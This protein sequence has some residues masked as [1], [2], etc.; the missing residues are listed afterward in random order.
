MNNS[1]TLHGYFFKCEYI[2]YVE[3][4]NTG[5]FYYKDPIVIKFKQNDDGVQGVSSGGKEVRMEEDTQGKPIYKSSITIKVVENL[6]YKPMDKVKLLNED[7]TYVVK[8]VYDSLRSTNSINNLQFPNKR[9][10]REYVLVMG[11]M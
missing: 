11:E 8:R 3:D 5:T 2:E 7:K 6:P 4:D 10:N 1:L 9:N